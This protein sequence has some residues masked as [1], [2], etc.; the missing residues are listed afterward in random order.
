VPLAAGESIDE[1]AVDRLVNEASTIELTSPA[2]AKRD[3]AKPTATITIE[4]KATGTATQAP[5]VVDAIADGNS[6]W[7]HD[8]SLPRSALVDKGRIEEIVGL[9]RDKVVKKPPP[10]PPPAT[11][12]TGA[13]SG[14]AAR[15]LPGAGAGSPVRL[16]AGAGA[17]SPVRPPTGA[18]A[19]S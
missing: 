16:P 7:V 2:D 12:G 17:G 5:V 14:S 8:R 4:R 3:A 1:V 11:P 10:P 19:G 6:Y 13:G 18:G 15:P 9:D